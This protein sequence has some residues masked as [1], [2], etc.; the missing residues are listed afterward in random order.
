MIEAID[1]KKLDLIWKPRLLI[2]LYIQMDQLVNQRGGANP[3][4]D[5]PV[6]RGHYTH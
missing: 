3:R 1:A 5:P 2:D 6:L 4:Y